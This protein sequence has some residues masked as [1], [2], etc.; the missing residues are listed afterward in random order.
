MVNGKVL[1]IFSRQV[2]CQDYTLENYS[3]SPGPRSCRMKRIWVSN[4]TG[5]DSNSKFSLYHM[6]VAFGKWS[7]IT[8]PQVPHPED[9]DY[10][11]GFVLV[12]VQWKQILQGGFTCTWL[13]KDAL[14]SGHKG[15]GQGDSGVR[16]WFK[17]SPQTWGSTSSCPVTLEC[18][19]R[20]SDTWSKARRLGFL[21]PRSHCVSGRAVEPFTGIQLLRGRILR[22]G[23]R[24]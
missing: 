13:M 8:I 9:T 5:A 11:I 1:K 10:H 15:E 19:W 18:T 21:Y 23:A 24:G 17:L 7:I 3:S 14:L 2:T 4:W 12:Q 22:T 6:C 20:L 16:V